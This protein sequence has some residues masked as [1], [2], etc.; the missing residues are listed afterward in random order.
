VLVAEN[1]TGR[2]RL[3]RGDVTRLGQAT[4]RAT[5]ERDGFAVSEPDDRGPA[6]ALAART[7]AVV[8]ATK[9]IRAAVDFP[10]TARI[11]TRLTILDWPLSVDDELQATV[12]AVTTF[13]L[14]NDVPAVVEDGSTRH[15]A[16]R[17]Y[18]TGGLLTLYEQV[19]ALVS[20]RGLS[21]FYADPR[22]EVFVPAAGDVVVLGALRYPIRI[23]RADWDARVAA[24]ESGSDLAAGLIEEATETASEVIE[25]ARRAAED[26]PHPLVAPR[27]EAFEQ[28]A[29]GEV[30][31]DLLEDSDFELTERFDP[32][33][34]PEESWVSCRVLRRRTDLVPPGT[35]R[36]PDHGL[37]DAVAWRVS[38]WQWIPADSEDDDDLDEEEAEWGSWELRANSPIA[39]ATVADLL[40]EPLQLWVRR[41]TE[42][43]VGLFESIELEEPEFTGAAAR[44][45]DELQALG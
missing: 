20:Q 44:L 38:Q 7:P 16:W 11:D 13:E 41:M 1:A 18:L 25:Q 28:R 5:L 19:G 26:D 33:G 3:A 15:L 43:A 8:T 27:P 36:D 2:Y 29:P 42:Q 6:A 4:V 39:A 40:P 21:A 30:E 12:S 14:A 10:P 17:G 32:E 45:K 22:L 35:V 37:E 31:L 34:N 24:A 9:Y 23:E